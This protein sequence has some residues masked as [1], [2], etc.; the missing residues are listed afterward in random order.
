ME[1][2]QSGIK[3]LALLTEALIEPGNE[4]DDLFEDTALLIS[5]LGTEGYFKKV[6]PSW[7]RLLGWSEQELCSRPWNDFIH[8]EDLES[9]N[10]VYQ[11]HLAGNLRKLHTNRYKA[12]NGTYKT[13]HWFVVDAPIINSKSLAIAIVLPDEVF[14]VK[15]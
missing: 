13:I 15:Q 2:D 1:D 11:S 14:S 5:V 7:T 9:T 8:P 3:K 12:K 4:F 6:S 10:E